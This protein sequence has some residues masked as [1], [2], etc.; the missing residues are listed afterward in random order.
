MQSRTLRWSAGGA[1]A[2]AVVLSFATFVPERG[3]IAEQHGIVAEERS[4][5][6]RS[7]G[8]AMRT[9]RGY[10]RGRNS[11]EE[12]ADA[13]TVIATMA[14]KIP[15]AFPTGT[16]MGANPES[17]AK[18]IIWA[19]WEEF[20]A[21]AVLLGNKAAILEAALTSGDASAA[22]SDLGTNGCGGCHNRFR[23][24]RN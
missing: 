15:D 2:L 19:E 6:M 5:L 10:L 7:M 8:G 16:G 14:A 12:A 1:L 3:A 4:Q 24:T 21:A 9:L 22:F 13:A 18:D 17:E 20:T 11:V 23:E